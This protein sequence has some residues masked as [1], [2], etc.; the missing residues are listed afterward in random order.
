[1]VIPLHRPEAV[2]G[3]LLVAAEHCSE[4]PEL[5]SLG[6]LECSPHKLRETACCYLSDSGP[7]TSTRM[8]TLMHT[9]LDHL[10]NTPH[11][12]TSS[13]QVHKALPLAQLFVA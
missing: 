1:M 10:F 11:S 7:Q 12:F 13:S 5:L 3:F 8:H 6:G 4:R 2:F 9:S